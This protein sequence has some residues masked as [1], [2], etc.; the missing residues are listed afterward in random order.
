MYGEI[1]F[2]YLFCPHLF[3]QNILCT[4]Y[5]CYNLVHC[6]NLINDCKHLIMSGCIW[7]SMQMNYVPMKMLFFNI[8]CSYCSFG[9]IYIINLYVLC[10]AIPI[11]K[12]SF[13]TGTQHEVRIEYSIISFSWSYPAAAWIYFQSSVV[14]SQLQFRASG[15]SSPHQTILNR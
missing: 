2:F 9:Q 3:A 5:N 7:Q 13:R 1:D 6:H 8:S 12:L 11:W 15:G 4:K 14:H 10:I